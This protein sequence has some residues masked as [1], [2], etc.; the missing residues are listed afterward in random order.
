MHDYISLLYR[1]YYYVFSFSKVSCLTSLSEQC[2]DI[3]DCCGGK[4]PSL[5]EDF[6]EYILKMY[7]NQTLNFGYFNKV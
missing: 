3:T 5:G 4:M 6:Y 7:S 1:I 2:N